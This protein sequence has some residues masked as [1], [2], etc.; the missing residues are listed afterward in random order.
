MYKII[1]ITDE[2]IALGNEEHQLVMVPTTATNYEN[3]KVGDVVELFRGEDTFIVTK[4]EPEYESEESAALSAES[5]QNK[6][7][8]PLEMMP[9]SAKAKWT[10]CF[11][12]D[13]IKIMKRKYLTKDGFFI[14]PK[15]GDRVCSTKVK[16]FTGLYTKKQIE[17]MAHSQ[18]VSE[19]AVSEIDSVTKYDVFSPT[20]NIRVADFFEEYAF[21][22]DEQNRLFSCKAFRKNMSGAGKGFLSALKRPDDDGIYSFDKILQFELLEDGK[23]IAEGGLG[24]ALAGGLL[25]GG[26]GAMVGASVGSK[27]MRGTCTTLQLKVVMNDLNTP[28]LYLEFMP[29]PGI[30]MSRETGTYR[31]ALDSAHRIASIIQIMLNQS[32]GE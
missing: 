14:C 2:Q 15:C 13:A 19:V 31:K 12:G 29:F 21:R 28:V 24:S 4:A 18:A 17:E 11:C 9:N 1:N 8:V 30:G 23:T 22:V 5:S 16:M 7:V 32:Q 20:M 26:V 25:F 3:P 6:E 10:C 27:T